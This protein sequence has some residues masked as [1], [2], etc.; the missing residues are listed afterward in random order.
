MS[1][2]SVGRAPNGGEDEAGDN[3]VE[4]HD[5]IG[6]GELRVRDREQPGVVHGLGRHAEQRCEQAEGDDDQNGQ[7]ARLFGDALIPG[8]EHGLDAGLRRAGG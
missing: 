6:V 1:C 4:A 3:G 7:Q 8:G 2:R 5:E